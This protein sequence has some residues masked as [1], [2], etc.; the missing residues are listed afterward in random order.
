MDE[1]LEGVAPEMP[2]QLAV[3]HRK[4]RAKHPDYPL[5][6]QVKDVDVPWQVTLKSYSPTTFTS[7]ALLVRGKDARHKID[8]ADCGTIRDI[9]GRNTF[10]GPLQFDERSVTLNP[11]GRTGLAGRGVLPRWGPNQTVT[12]VVTRK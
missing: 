10:E 8:P 12:L 1:A 4:S 7:K 9:R 11:R 5:R 2:P 3:S 6:Y